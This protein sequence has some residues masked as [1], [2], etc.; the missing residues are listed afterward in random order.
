M[1]A[2]GQSRVNPA[3]NTID[4]VARFRA[5]LLA[6]YRANGRHHLPWRTSGEPYHVYISEIMLQQTQVKTVLERFYAPF[7]NRF[8]TLANLA[9]A[10]RADVMK[11][12]EGLGYYTRAANLHAAAQQSGGEL[13]DTIEGLLALPG[14]GQNTAHAVGCFGF[15]HAVPVMEANVKRVLCRLFAAAQPSPA[16]LWE[17]AWAL[18]DKAHPFDYNQA[19]M[20]LGAMVCTPRAPQCPICPAADICRGRRAPESYPAPK[21]AK[22]TPVRTRRIVVIRDEKARYYA[23][24]RA[25]RFLGG[26]YGFLE[27]DPSEEAIILAGIRCDLAQATP[28]GHVSQAYSHFTLEADIALLTVT[29]RQMRKAPEW[30]GF[31]LADLKTLALSRAEW[32]IVALIEGQT[33]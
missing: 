29:S 9:A 15:G 30:S 18:L 20:D 14:I 24:P 21:A 11:A 8:P 3:K 13:P 32:K 19:M 28:L 1:T 27:L 17:K 23:A 31:S 25:T 12:W 22:V 2:K 10:P 6:W 33:A 16:E 5:A 7:L 4:A 26:L